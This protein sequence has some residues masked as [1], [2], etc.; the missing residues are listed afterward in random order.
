[1][2]PAGRAAWKPGL[3]VA[4][5][6]ARVPLCAAFLKVTVRPLTVT[7]PF[8]EPVI[9]WPGGSVKVTVQP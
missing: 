3:V 2:S 5:P 4:A 8:H 6:G 1:M 7:A 9:V